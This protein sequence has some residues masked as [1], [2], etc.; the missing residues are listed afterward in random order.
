MM[1]AGVGAWSSLEGAGWDRTGG[2][3]RSNDYESL[4]NCAR[5]RAAEGDMRFVRDLCDFCVD[6]RFLRSAEPTSM[7]LPPR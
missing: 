1:L 7:I 4:A 5:L 3:I 6:P 2:L